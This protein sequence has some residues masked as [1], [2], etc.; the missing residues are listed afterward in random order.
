MQLDHEGRDQVIY[1]QSRQLKPAER[2]YP[3]HDKELLAMKYA[4]AKF[5][6]YLLGNTPFVCVKPAP[7]LR[8]P[9]QPLP[10]PSECW[11]SV[12]MDFVFGLPRDSRRKTGIVVF[13]DRFSTMVHL[14]A[15]AAEVT[16]VQTARLFV[17][18]VF[19]H[20]GMPNDVVADRDPR[21][22]ARFWQEVF[23]QVGED[24]RLR[25]NNRRRQLIQSY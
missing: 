14:A 9:L 20:H 11:E 24:L 16:S 23:T 8:A 1:Y 3:V 25:P 19:K 5:R 4:L 17:D 18:M 7:H 6:V 12:S 13:V 22:T 2:N 10:T 15:V 21:F